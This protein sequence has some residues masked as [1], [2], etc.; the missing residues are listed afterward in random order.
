[1]DIEYLLLLQRLREGAGWLLTPMME[2]ISEL[3]ASSLT[4]GVAA[5]PSCSGRWT[6][7]S[8]AF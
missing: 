5:L 8:A 7:A 4:I 3:A 6:G 2:L 1:M